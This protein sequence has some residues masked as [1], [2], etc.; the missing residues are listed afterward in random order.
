MPDRFLKETIRSSKN[1]NSLSDFVFRVWAYLI[2]YVDDFGR[3]SADPELLKGFV[4][5]RRRGIT[6]E[7]IG[8]ALETLASKGMITLYSVDGE[9]YF[10]FPKWD[11]HQ[12]ARDKK[13]KFPAPENNMQ[14][15][16]KKLKEQDHD[17][18]T[19][20]SNSNRSL[21]NDPK[22]NTDPENKP[23]K[24]QQKNALSLSAKEY[25]EKINPNAS[26]KEMEKLNQFSGIM[27]DFVIHKVIEMALEKSVHD[28]AAIFK[29][30]SMAQ[31]AGVTNFVEFVLFLKKKK[32]AKNVA[33]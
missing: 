6:E 21:S 13:S 27:G 22:R 1:V 10:C 25:L 18:K 12:Q 16:E 20:K 29:M 15:I 2:T 33:I 17:Y 4:F 28:P 3:G 24:K 9:S 11:V 8:K 31:K 5:P 19:A 7:Q 14:S 26:D 23:D 30:L 32:G